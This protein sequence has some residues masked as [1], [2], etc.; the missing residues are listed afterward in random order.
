MFGSKGQNLKDAVL[1][2]SSPPVLELA[3]NVKNLDPIKIVKRDAHALRVVSFFYI[4]CK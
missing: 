3:S 1:G 4:C 2:K